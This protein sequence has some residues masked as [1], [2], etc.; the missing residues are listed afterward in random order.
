MRLLTGQ[1]RGQSACVCR[2]RPPT[3]S[4][5]APGEQTQLT[6]KGP[7]GGYHAR[8]Q[9]GLATNRVRLTT[10]SPS[11]SLR[12]GEAR[13]EAPDSARRGRASR[14]SLI[15]CASTE[16]RGTTSQLQQRSP[17]RDTCRGQKS[18]S[19]PQAHWSFGSPGDSL[20]RGS[21]PMTIPARFHETSAWAPETA[22]VAQAGI[23]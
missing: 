3:T 6:N 9:R 19:P 22:T 8:T 16:L 11:V 4:E 12:Q 17:A 13:T 18:L 14:G 20:I 7:A 1:H 5:T 21:A 10:A 2:V 23:L 15:P